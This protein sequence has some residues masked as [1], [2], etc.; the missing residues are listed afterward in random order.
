MAGILSGPSMT[1]EDSVSHSAPVA[2]VASLNIDTVLQVADLNIYYYHDLSALTAKA[3]PIKISSYHFIVGGTPPVYHPYESIVIPGQN[4]Q[5][6]FFNYIKT[7]PE[8]S[9]WTEI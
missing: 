2:R 9:G 7:L 5:V 6:N 1:T 4:V 3:R 8:F